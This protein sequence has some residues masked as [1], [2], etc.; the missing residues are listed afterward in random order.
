MTILH[1]D[2][3]PRQGATGPDSHRQSLA[4]GGQRRGVDFASGYMEHIC[5]FFGV[6]EVHIIDA[7]GSKRT[8]GEVIARGRQQIDA[9]LNTTQA[10]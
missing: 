10:A 6:K 4:G 1:I 5:H 3:S 8:P 2:T 9:I 7:S